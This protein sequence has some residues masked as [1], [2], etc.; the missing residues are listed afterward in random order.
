MKF[1][2]FLIPDGPHGDRRRGKLYEPFL[3]KHGRN[4][5]LGTNAFIY[6]PNGLIV[7]NHVYIG[8]NSY[9]GQ[10]E[11]TLHD[12][13]LIGNFVSITASNHLRQNNSY[14]FGGYESKPI[15][16][17][18]GTWIGANSCLVAGV[19]IG[20][21]CLIAAGSVVTESFIDNHKIIAGIPARIIKDLN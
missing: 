20:E 16:I 13:V 21:G 9:I 17:G 18:K 6:N 11:V 8:F 1:R 2:S 3:K 7:G 15:Q 12:E 10:G 5:K 14:R 4:F 19:Q